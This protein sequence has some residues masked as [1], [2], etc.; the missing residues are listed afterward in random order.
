MG[1]TV[2]F[3]DHDDERSGSTVSLEYLVRS[4]SQSGYKVVVLSPKNKDQ[5]R[6]SFGATIDLLHFGT[7][8]F[9]ALRLSTHAATKVSLASM[10]GSQ[11]I[12]HNLAKF[13][14]GYVVVSRAIRSVTPD[15]VYVN[16]HVVIQASV[17]ACL[18]GIPSVIHIRSQITESGRGKI[19]RFLSWLILHCNK[20]VFAITEVEARQLGAR[21]S[22]LRKLRIIGEFIPAVGPPLLHSRLRSSFGLPRLKKVV[23]M[24]GGI[25]NIKG[26]LE[27]LRAAIRV[28]KARN[29]VL[30]VLAGRGL[31]NVEMK[32]K[33]YFQECQSAIR[34]IGK[35]NPPLILGEISHPLE[36]IQCSDILVSPST[37]SHFSRPVV[38]AWACG[39]PVVAAGTEHMRNL[40]RPNKDG[41]LFPPGDENALA[42]CLLSLLANRELRREMGVAG[43]R[44]ASLE[45]DA[46]KNTTLVVNLC[47]S[48]LLR[49]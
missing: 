2:L 27:F 21:G 31:S 49:K 45:F 8:R 24:L 23:L 3:V 47:N 42:E 4:F 34:T 26:T 14:L 1:K 46:D 37:L 48:L 9:H 41:L 5:A 18:H 28:S 19:Q 20:Q 15:L 40:V 16:E 39:K 33:S 25:S 10:Q 44:R 17:A 32:Q 12:A 6:A 13:L 30:F 11:W 43:K 29:D 7:K 38:E 36:L 35:K 22:A